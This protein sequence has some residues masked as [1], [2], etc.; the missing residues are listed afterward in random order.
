VSDSASPEEQPTLDHPSDDQRRV[1]AGREFAPETTL[2]AAPD[3]NSFSSSPVANADGAFRTFGDYEFSPDR[4]RLASVSND[5]TVKL[6]DATRLEHEQ[7]PVLT[8]PVRVGG[9]GDRVAFS[10]DSRHLVT[11]GEEHTVKVWDASTGQEIRTLRGHTGDVFAVA[12]SPNGRWIAS[13]GEDTTVRIW[14]AKSGKLLHTL[15]GHIGLVG[16]LAFSPDSQRLVSGSRDHTVRVW[17]L[18]RLDK[19]LKE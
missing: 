4:C 5:F 10:P 6:W 17:D 19:K 13:A 7:K 3:G 12:V 15:R 8:I 14:D 18:T 2:T 11:G 1:P 16:T 9:F